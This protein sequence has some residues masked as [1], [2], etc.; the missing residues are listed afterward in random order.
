MCCELPVKEPAMLGSAITD[1]GL[2]HD[3]TIDIF[4]NRLAGRKIE[5]VIALIYIY[6]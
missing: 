2:Y 1:D 6:V 3:Y 4:Y 5:I